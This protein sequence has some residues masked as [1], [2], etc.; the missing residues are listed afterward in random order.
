MDAVLSDWETADIPERARA[1]L[2][3]LDC[4]TLRP[5]KLDETFV[6]QLREDGLDDPALREA[7]NISFHFNMM[8]R[9]SDAFAFE[10]LDA[11]QEALHTKMLTSRENSS[12]ESRPIQSG[13]GTLTGRFGPQSWH[14]PAYRFCR[15]QAKPRR[16]CARQWKPLWYRQ[17]DGSAPPTHR[18]RLT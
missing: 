10:M 7:A 14:A 17:E 15:R 16:R 18:C 8:N 5:M 2:R 6:R 13:F 12:R 9:L 1:A 11:R 4:L 3:L